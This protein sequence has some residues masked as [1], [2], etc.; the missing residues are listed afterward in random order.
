MA[1]TALL[2][3]GS[4]I[5]D[6]AEANIDK[7]LEAIADRIGAVTASSGKYSTPCYSQG[8]IVEGARYL[9]QVIAVD[10]DLDAPAIEII[11]KA[12]ET[13][14]GRDAEARRR[15]LV[16]IDI[17]LI[18]YGSQTIRPHDLTSPYFTKGHKL[19]CTACKKD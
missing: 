11:C 4:N 2:C 8:R 13:A 14:L 6:L 9:N 1:T 17:D 18:T 12:I 10:T 19:I 16:P 7:A 5:A 3:L 15:H